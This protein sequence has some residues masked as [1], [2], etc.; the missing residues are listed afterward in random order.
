[1]VYEECTGYL[2]KNPAL[3]SGRGLRVVLLTLWHMFSELEQMHYLVSTGAVSAEEKE[4]ALA[5][6]T[7]IR[8]DLYPRVNSRDIIGLRRQIHYREPEVNYVFNKYLMHAELLGRYRK[9]IPGNE[10]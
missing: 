7:R 6:I 5:F 9:C 2:R 10:G 3:P 1:M 8:K 4:D